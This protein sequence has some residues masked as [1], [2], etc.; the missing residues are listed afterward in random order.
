M[1]KAIAQSIE[2]APPANRP[3]ALTGKGFIENIEAIRKRARRRIEQGSSTDA[4]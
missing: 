2:H 4:D 1:N 3:G